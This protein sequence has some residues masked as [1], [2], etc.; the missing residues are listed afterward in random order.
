MMFRV[1]EV[2]AGKE[3]AVVLDNG[4]IST[5]FAKH[6]ERM[7][8]SARRPGCFFKYLDHNSPDILTHPFI[9]NRTEKLA[10]SLRRYGIGA[11]SSGEIRPTLDNGKERHIFGADVLEI[12]IHLRRKLDIV[13]IQDT[14][15]VARNPVM[16]QELECAQGLFMRGLLPFGQP[17][18][19]V[20]FLGAIQTEPDSKALPSQET[21]PLFVDENPVRLDAV[22]N[23]TIRGLVLA[24]ERDHLAE[25]IKAQ[26]RGFPAM[27]GKVDCRT[28]RRGD[29]LDNVFLKEG[30]RH[31]ELLS[32]G[33]KMLLPQIV[34]VSAVQVADGANRLGKNLKVA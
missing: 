23:T 31:A 12:P 3:V 10:E 32:L 5:G 2:V 29:V 16:P 7:L 17:I 34:T 14:E 26:N 30:V 9:E 19:V 28:R 20:H 8:E 27:P 18:M 33:I 11:H 21:A 22:A 15:N 1:N 13:V 6:A 25:K 24:L 4:K